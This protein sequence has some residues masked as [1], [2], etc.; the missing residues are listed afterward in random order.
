MLRSLNQVHEE[1]DPTNRYSIFLPRPS[2]ATFNVRFRPYRPRAVRVAPKKFDNDLKEKV[3]R[4]KTR[5]FPSFR[6]FNIRLVY[7]PII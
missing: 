6:M 5:N 4:S 2:I 7:C 3:R 1:H